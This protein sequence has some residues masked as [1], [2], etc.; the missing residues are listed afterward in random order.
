HL[1]RGLPAIRVS[2]A[3]LRQ[4]VLN[5]ITNASDAI[6]DRDGV[7]RVITGRVT[8]KGESATAALSTLADGDYAKLEVSDTGCGMSA[9]TQAKV[10]D[11]FFSTKSA[12]RGLGLAV[13]K[14]IVRTRG[15]AINLTSEPGRGTTFQ[16]L[17]PC[18]EGDAHTDGLVDNGERVVVPP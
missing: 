17:L 1:D 15:G 16:I 8:L 11:P 9:E 3:Q 10:F 5:L 2:A 13:V 6:G 4:I 7:I 18:T 12:G 14:G